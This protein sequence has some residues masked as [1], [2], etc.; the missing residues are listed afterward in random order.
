[1]KFIKDFAKGLVIITL[2]AAV[3]ILP[4]AFYVTTESTV[5]SV[6]IALLPLLGLMFM[7]I[8]GRKKA[9]VAG[10]A[11]KPK[12]R[13]GKSIRPAMSDAFDDAINFDGMK[14]VL[15]LDDD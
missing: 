14:P 7:I 8:T 2:L 9:A 10:A 3:F 4:A 13:K 5:I 15:H 12:P 11:K 6:A 1:M